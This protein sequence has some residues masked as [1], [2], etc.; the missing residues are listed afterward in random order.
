MMLATE[1]IHLLDMK[2]QSEKKKR[3]NGDTRV[4][5]RKARCY[6]VGGR[7]GKERH[8]KEKYKCE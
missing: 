8:E 2:S 1:L 7:R 3:T 5:E 4:V 6:V